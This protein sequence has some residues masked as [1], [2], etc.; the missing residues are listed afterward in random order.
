MNERTLVP[1]PS[2]RADLKFVTADAAFT[3]KGL[4][5]DTPYT[6]MFGPDK[7]GATNKVCACC[8]L[9]VLVPAH[10]RSSAGT[11]RCRASL[12]RPPLTLPPR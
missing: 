10:R 12:T 2:R 4:K 8:R 7:C 5:D 11:A 3:P 1:C 6:V 9:W